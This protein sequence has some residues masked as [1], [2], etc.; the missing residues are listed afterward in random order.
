MLIGAEL[1]AVLRQRQGQGPRRQDLAAGRLEDRRRH[2]LGLD[3][4]RSRAQ[5]DLLRHRQSRGRGTRTSARATTNG[6]PAS[7]PATSTPAR[8]AGSTSSARTTCSTRTAS[9]SRSCSTSTWNGQPRKVLVRPERNGYL[10]VI[11][12]ATGEVLSAEPFGTINATSGVDLKTGRLQYVEAK[13]PQMNKVVRDICP[14]AS[15]AKDWNPSAYSPKTG[16]LYIPHSQSVHGRRGTRA[17]TTSPARPMSA[18]KVRMKPGPGGHRGVFTA[19]D[20]RQAKSA[21]S[22]NENFPVWSGALATAGDVVFYGTMEG[23][24]K[25][26]DARTG[27]LLWQFKTGSG[28]IGQPIDLSRPGRQAVRRGPVRRRRLGGRHR[29]RRPRR[30][31]RHR[32]ARLRQRHARPEGRDHERRNPP[33][34]PPSVSA[35]GIAARPLPPRG[36]EPTR[37]KP[38]RRGGA[39]GIEC[40]RLKLGAFLSAAGLRLGRSVLRPRDPHPYPS[41]QGGGDSRIVR[42]RPIGRA[43]ARSGLS[44]GRASSACP[45][46]ARLRRSQQPAVLERGARGVREQDRRSHR[47]RTSARPSPTPGGRSGA[48]SCAI[49]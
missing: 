2:G 16:L 33:C 7:S 21:W 10:Y 13:K 26:V 1:Q 8:R 19:W 31:R 24:F 45:R 27:K 11:D 29:R 12:R 38:E 37:A 5:P 3:L 44:L 35:A 49:R 42:S 25:A 48:G 28:I 15:G 23:W 4:L 41:P 40:W 32:G 22:I 39:P 9:T 30:P 34:V 46:A 17:R 43:C 14:T 6:P 47:R 18:P 36:G 20:V